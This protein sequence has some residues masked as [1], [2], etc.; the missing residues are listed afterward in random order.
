MDLRKLLGIVSVPVE[1]YIIQDRFRSVLH[2]CLYGHGN[3]R[4][5]VKRNLC[6]LF[7]VFPWLF[8]HERKVHAVS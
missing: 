4:N 1:H 7:R 2:P 3:T 8:N 5:R 6:V